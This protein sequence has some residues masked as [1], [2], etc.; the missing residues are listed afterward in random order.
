MDA[1]NLWAYPAETS[2]P[3]AEKIRKKPAACVSAPLFPGA[4]SGKGRAT[5]GGFFRISSSSFGQPLPIVAAQAGGRKIRK[6]P[7]RGVARRSR[8]RLAAGQWPQE[9]AKGAKG[10]TLVSAMSSACPCRG[11][12]PQPQ[13]VRI[14]DPELAAKGLAFATEEDRDVDAF[15]N[16]RPC[17]R[18]LCV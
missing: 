13:V 11:R 1:L 17:G 8:N 14:E 16:R 18:T 10:R 12:R 2:K 7:K 5:A 15:C 6:K 9:S 4:V 3:T